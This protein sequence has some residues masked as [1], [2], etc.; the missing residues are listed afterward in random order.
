MQNARPIDYFDYMQELQAKAGSPVKLTA[1]TI[2]VFKNSEWMQHFG[3]VTQVCVNLV[4]KNLGQD[5][6]PAQTWKWV[7]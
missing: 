2:E 3:L 5:M 1:Q 7:Q 6:N 4:L